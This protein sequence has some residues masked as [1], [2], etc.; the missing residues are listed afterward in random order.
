MP[1]KTAVSNKINRMR[2]WSIHVYSRRN[3]SWGCCTIPS[4]D[5]PW[6]S[7]NIHYVRIFNKPNWPLCNSAELMIHAH[8]CHCV[9]L[10]NESE[11]A[12][13]WRAKSFCGNNLNQMYFLCIYFLLT[14]FLYSSAIRNIKKYFII[15]LYFIIMLL[16]YI[17]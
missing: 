12:L 7:E 9:S 1:L 2:N 3:T 11:T 6:L 8:L 10:H 17:F 4:V 14:F 16:N 5:R 15:Y 13:N